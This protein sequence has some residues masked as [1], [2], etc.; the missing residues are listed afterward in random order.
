MKPFLLAGF[1]VLMISCMKYGSTDRL[2]DKPFGSWVLLS[3]E[4]RDSTGR[5]L[6]LTDFSTETCPNYLVVTRD[7]IRTITTRSAI[8]TE[9]EAHANCYIQTADAY[10]AVGADELASESN[11]SERIKW[12]AD[13]LTIESQVMVLGEGG[14]KAILSYRKLKGVAN[15]DLTPCSCN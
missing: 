14:K 10:A 2:E 8:G 3:R 11:P 15:P 5:S 7:T 12:N 1:S 6:G 4:Y 13:E 9:A